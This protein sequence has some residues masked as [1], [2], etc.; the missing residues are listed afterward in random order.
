MYKAKH[1]KVR[2]TERGYIILIDGVGQQRIRSYTVLHSSQQEP[3]FTMWVQ[4]DLNR[5]TANHDSE[6][7]RYHFEKLEII[8]EKV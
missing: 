4:G 1:I 3:T 2:L 6:A 8:N 5:R 7:I